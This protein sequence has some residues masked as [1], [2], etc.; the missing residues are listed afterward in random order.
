MCEK[1]SLYDGL[2][3]MFVILGLCLGI[4]GCAYLVGKTLNEEVE[5]QARLIEAQTAKLKIEKLDKIENLDIIV[6]S[7]TDNENHK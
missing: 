4:G 1:S 7:E 2:G 5:V 3:T 6:K